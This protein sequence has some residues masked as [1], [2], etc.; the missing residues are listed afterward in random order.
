[1][2]MS[3]N[4]CIIFLLFWFVM[5]LYKMK[6]NLNKIILEILECKMKTKDV[7]LI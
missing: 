4:E 6:T 1:M 7:E 2:C 5:L 3:G